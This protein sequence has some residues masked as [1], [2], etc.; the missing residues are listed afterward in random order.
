MDRNSGDVSLPWS[1]RNREKNHNFPLEAVFDPKEF[2]GI[3]PNEKKTVGST[4]EQCSVHPG[5]LFDIGD[6]FLPSYRGIIIS[7]YKDPY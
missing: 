6:E 5:W 3:F 7:H 4:I 2:C 1:T